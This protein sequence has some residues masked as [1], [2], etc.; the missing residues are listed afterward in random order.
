M[1]IVIA[2]PGFDEGSKKYS[3][4]LRLFIKKQY[5]EAFMFPTTDEAKM[6]FLKMDSDDSSDSYDDDEEYWVDEDI[7]FKRH[8]YRVLAAVLKM[9]ADIIK[10]AANYNDDVPAYIFNNARYYPMFKDCIGAIDGTHVR[11]SVPL[12][13]QAKYIGRK[14]Y[15]TQNIMAVCDF[16]MCFTFVWAG[17]EGTAH[18]TRIFNEALRRPELHFPHPTGDKYYVVDAGGRY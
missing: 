12:N 11:A 5:R 9:S 18:D 8:F 7:D 1:N 16:N 6:E 13:E 10:P 14:G 3:Q 4:A 2:F 15:A 17:W